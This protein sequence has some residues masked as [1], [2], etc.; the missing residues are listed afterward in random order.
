[1]RVGVGSI[2]LVF[3]E[4]NRTSGYLWQMKNSDA[5]PV[6]QYINSV[7]IMNSQ[8]AGTRV[9]AGG[10]DMLVLGVGAPG[11]TYLEAE[12]KRPWENQAAK[13][14]KIQIIGE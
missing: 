11:E 3:L 6:L 7:Y 1:L 13:T 5:S 12:Y 9:G 4:T 14:I 2:V 8:T 10:W